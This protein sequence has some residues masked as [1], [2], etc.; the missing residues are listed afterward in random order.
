MSKSFIVIVTEFESAT[1]ACADGSRKHHDFDVVALWVQS[2]HGCCSFSVQLSAAFGQSGSPSLELLVSQFDT[3]MVQGC[4]FTYHQQVFL[5]VPVPFGLEVMSLDVLALF[6]SPWF[7]LPL[8]LL[9]SCCISLKAFLNP[10]RKTLISASIVWAL[11]CCV[12]FAS[13]F[14]F[15]MDVLFLFLFYLFYIYICRLVVFVV[16]VLS[17]DSVLFCLYCEIVVFLFSFFSVLFDVIFCQLFVVFW[18]LLS[19]ILSLIYLQSAP[20][21]IKVE[22]LWR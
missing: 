21:H 11:V 16:V 3:G 20:N 10:W 7:L 4:F 2:S 22:C 19:L 5:S 8:M 18:W 1:E 9:W 6:I 15:K 13:V 14:A 12:R 17:F